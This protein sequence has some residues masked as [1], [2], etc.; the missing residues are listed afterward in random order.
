MARVTERPPLP[1]ATV[2]ATTV[3][4]PPAAR[5][6]AAPTVAPSV[7]DST[8][9][10]T[11]P[12]QPVVPGTEWF[13]RRIHRPL[14]QLWARGFRFLFVLDAVGLFG[15][16]VAINLARFG[17]DWPTYGPSH[18]WIGFSIATGIHL[19]INYLAGLYDREPRLGSRPW[20]P[21]ALVAMTIGVATQ[22][23]ASYLVLERY[24]MPRLNLAVFTFAGVAVLVFNRRMSLVLANRRKGPP[25]VVLVGSDTDVKLAAAH[26][27]ESDRDAIVVGH[28][29]TPDTLDELVESTHA[30]DVLLLD[31][32]AFGSVF[33]EPLTSLEERGV[34]FLQRIS[35]RET[36][37]GLQAVRQ[38]AGMPFVRFR[39]H[40]VPSYKLRLKRMFDLVIVVVTA[41]VWLVAV[42]LLSLFVLVR[43][44]RPVLY[45]QRRVG[46]DG[47]HFNLLKFRTMIRD[48]E[49]AGAQLASRRDP[50]VVHGLMWMRETR[51]DEL[52]QLF[53][54]VRGHMSLVGPRPERPDLVDAITRTVPGYVRR[55]ELPPGLTG[56]AQVSGRYATDAE[57]KLGY[58]LQYIV[59]WSLGLDVE[60]LARTLWVVLTRRV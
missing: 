41:P 38:V 34:G 4:A 39:A 29:P 6:A 14:N 45:R 53:H 49:S 18:Y 26:L 33:P 48:A 25:R 1:T 3:D 11:R 9:D 42:G 58:D 57:Y 16:M 56:L 12:P 47:E 20:L 7:V 5:A 60:I 52:P 59:N 23:L 17:F 28:T 2:G 40:T 10:V 27:A 15:M 35:A 54:V 8:S 51:L 30:S 36:L 50:R 46:R 22:G 32:A 43:A 31:V 24:L 37:L 21:R 55:N 19:T 13:V 44:G